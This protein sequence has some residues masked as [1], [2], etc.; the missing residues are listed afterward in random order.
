[1]HRELARLH[2]RKRTLIQE[3][4]AQREVLAGELEALRESFSWVEKAG[5]FLRQARPILLAAAP[6]A[7]FL[8]ARRKGGKL[9]LLRQAFS[10]FQAV[11]FVAKA[12]KQVRAKDGLLGATPQPGHPTDPVS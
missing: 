3:S 6:V 5:S 8:L 1:M 10:A 7:G 4:D 2:E 12:W 9:S 11:S